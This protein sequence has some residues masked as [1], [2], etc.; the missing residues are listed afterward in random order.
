[1]R[2]FPRL[3][4]RGATEFHCVVVRYQTLRFA[5][6]LIYR[7]NSNSLSYIAETFA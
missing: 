1:M 6:L 7:A 2:E 4:K 5:S 3:L